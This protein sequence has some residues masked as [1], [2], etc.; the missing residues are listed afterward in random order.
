MEGFV[1]FFLAWHS[2]D[3]ICNELDH[4]HQNDDAT[5]SQQRPDH[6]ATTFRGCGNRATTQ[7]QQRRGT[8]APFIPLHANILCFVE[9]QDPGLRTAASVGAMSPRLSRPEMTTSINTNCKEVA[10]LGHDHFLSRSH[11]WTTGTFTPAKGR[12]VLPSALYRHGLRRLTLDI[13]LFSKL[14]SVSAPAASISSMNK[15]RTAS[16]CVAMDGT[17]SLDFC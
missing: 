13:K 5:T 6:V 14:P 9:T 8:V 12:T 17:S 1:F 7:S 10:W 2:N 3:V 11:D 4:D 16:H 15:K